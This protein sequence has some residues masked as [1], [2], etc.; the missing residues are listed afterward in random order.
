MC[1][2]VKYKYIFGIP[3]E[4]VHSIRILDT[5]IVDYI[6]TIVL[7]IFVAYI[8]AYPLVLITIICFILG[9]ILH[10]LFCIET[11]T[12]RFIK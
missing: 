10:A 2:F 9:E 8:T 4:G 12:V 11:N 7:A 3:N 1:I 6:L 5:A